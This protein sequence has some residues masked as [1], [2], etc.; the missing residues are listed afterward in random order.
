MTSTPI[1]TSSTNE[2]NVF[3]A[4]LPSMLYGFGD[5]KNI[6]LNSVK[7]IDAMLIKYIHDLVFFLL[8]IIFMKD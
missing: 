5:N 8:H 6:N 4:D 2:T 3:T 1:N 7:L